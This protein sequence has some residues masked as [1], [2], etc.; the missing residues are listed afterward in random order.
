MVSTSCVNSGHFITVF[1]LWR[2]ILILGYIT[3]H[4]MMSWRQYNY[5]V[6]DGDEKNAFQ[7]KKS[8][9]LE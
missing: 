2:G 7:H 9:I 1:F 3:S 4:Q 5:G 6:I 8:L